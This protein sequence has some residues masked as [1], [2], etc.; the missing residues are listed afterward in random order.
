MSLLRLV[1]EDAVLAARLGGKFGRR[2]H[3]ESEYCPSGQQPNTC[4]F[5]LSG[6]PATFL[7]P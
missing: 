4:T 2:K 3:V 7:L 1:A 5:K 6:T